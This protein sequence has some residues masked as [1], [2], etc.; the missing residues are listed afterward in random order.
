MKSTSEQ[1][2]DGLKNQLQKS[3]TR[4]HELNQKIYELQQELKLANQSLEGASESSDSLHKTLCEKQHELE[5][6]IK[7]NISL[8]K[9]VK[10]QDD[11]IQTLVEIC[12]KL[13]KDLAELRGKLVDE[14]N[15][16]YGDS[17][18]QSHKMF[19]ILWPNGVP[20]ENYKDVLSLSRI[21]DKMFRIANKKDAFGYN[22]YRDIAGYEFP[23]E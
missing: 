8:S 2:V 16:A 9:M 6:Q 13:Q 5:K 15:A 4:Q 3:F 11:E 23:W 14:K 1:E 22:P 7:E 21:I 18:H 19:E 20:V 10:E 12:E 17:F